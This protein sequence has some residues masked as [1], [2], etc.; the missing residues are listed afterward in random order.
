MEK[1]KL[2]VGIGC[3]IGG[4][5]LIYIG[6]RML[7]SQLAFWPELLTLAGISM[8]IMAVMF[9]K[10]AEESIYGTVPKPPAIMQKVMPSMPAKAK[11]AKKAGKKKKKG[12]K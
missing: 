7:G 5:F 8:V 3:G 9:F 6:G 12:R 1:V 4:L 11:T 10:Q 2:G